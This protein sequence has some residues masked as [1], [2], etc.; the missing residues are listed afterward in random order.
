MS[1]EETKNLIRSA[2]ELREKYQ[3]DAHRPTYHFIAPESIC[4]PFDPQGCIYWKGRYHLFYA[5][6]VEDVGLWGH[7]SSTDLLHWRHHPT[8]FGVAPDDPEE[9]IY[10]GGALINKEGVPTMIYHGVNAGTCIATSVDDELIHWNKL[11]SNPV[12]PLPRTGDADYGVYHVWDTCGWVDGETYYSIC[13]NKPNTPPEIEGDAAYLFKSPDLVNWE[14]VHPFYESD[15]CWTD[16]DEDCSCPDFFPL[17]D[18]HVL[19]FISHNQGTQYYIGR[20]EDERFYPEHHGRMNWPGGPSFAQESLLDGKGRRVFWAWL[21]DSQSRDAQLRSGWGGVMSLPKVLSLTDDGMLC[22]EPAEE[23][24]VLRLNH[25]KHENIELGT[26]S[27]QVLED[28]HGDCL[29]LV[30]EVVPPN[31]GEFGLKVRCSPDGEEQ[32][33]ITFHPAAKKLKI[34]TARSSLSDEVV[35]PWPT[36]QASFFPKLLEGRAD[37]RIQEAPFALSSREQLRLQVFLDRSVL[38][39]FANGRQCISQRIYPTRSDSLGTVLFSRGGSTVV[40]SLD[41][42]DM[43]A[44][45]PW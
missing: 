7:A 15:R 17:G 35:Q 33:V 11:P 10:A 8:T 21:C 43:A 29:E 18:K 25:R 5:L 1:M 24:S 23:L 31:D 30:L 28:V 44:T 37:V 12:I 9:Q 26:D 19:M 38:E 27:E 2:R 41:V 39:V 40:R 4:H 34:D 13:G 42:W 36:P 32:T 16:S 20:Y 6:Q 45:N 14:Y 22:I 3:A